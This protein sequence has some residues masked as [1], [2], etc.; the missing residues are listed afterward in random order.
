VERVESHTTFRVV[1][2]P[3]DMP[4]EDIVAKKPKPTPEIG[5]RM[6]AKERE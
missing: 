4:D 2:E 1:D 5:T 6:S 3:I